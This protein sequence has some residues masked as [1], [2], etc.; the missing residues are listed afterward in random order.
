MNGF[1]EGWCF[2]LCFGK[3]RREGRGGDLVVVGYLPGRSLDGVCTPLF[4][5]HY[6][7]CHPFR[8][9]LSLLS[10]PGSSPWRHVYFTSRAHPNP[11][12][13]GRAWEAS[14]DWLATL[15][16][17]GGIRLALT[18]PVRNTLKGLS[19]LIPRYSGRGH[20]RPL[21]GCQFTR[22]TTADQARN[23][24]D[25]VSPFFTFLRVTLTSQA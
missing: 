14:P 22:D 10:L 23:G 16:C 6:F 8:F 25:W 9:C 17:S 24:T 11:G 2:V 3:Y 5:C 13:A 21:K 1:T 15:S 4:L 7:C 12:T 19:F 18:L 20:H